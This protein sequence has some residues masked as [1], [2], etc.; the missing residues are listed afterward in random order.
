M[1]ALTIVRRLLRGRG[2]RNQARHSVSRIPR[3]FGLEK[4]L[5]SLEDCA[6]RIKELASSMTACSSARANSTDLYHP[7]EHLHPQNAGPSARGKIGC[8]KEFNPEILQGVRAREKEVRLNYKLLMAVR[9]PPSEGTPRK[10]EFFTLHQWWSRWESN[11]RP[12]ECDSSAL[13]TE[14]RPRYWLAAFRYCSTLSFK[15]GLF[16]A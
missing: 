2:R 15:S 10:E 5:L 14:L 3:R 9:T 7:D 4:G 13:P 11:P 16:N 6:A 1:I 12:L 8:K